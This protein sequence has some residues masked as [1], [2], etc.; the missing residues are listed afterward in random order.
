MEFIQIKKI[1]EYPAFC[2]QA[3]LWF[4]QKWG[5]AE[6]AYLQRMEE[7][8]AKPLGITQWYLLTGKEGEIVAGAGVIE[9]DFHNRKDLSPNLCALYVEEAYRKHGI[10][11]YMLNFIVQDIRALGIQN[12]YLITDHTTFYEKCGWKFFTNV[13]DA[14][15]NV[16]RMYSAPAK[17]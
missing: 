16:C 11:R 3:A 14:E 9:N 5:I 13:V 1:R 17:V 15:G 4:A 7:C 6:Q 12:L 8:V 2:K 10:A